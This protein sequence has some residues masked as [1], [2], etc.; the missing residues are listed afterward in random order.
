MYLGCSRGTYKPLGLLLYISKFDSPRKKAAFAG[1]DAT[2]TQSGEFEAAHNVMS[3][4]GLPY[5]RKV[6]F[7][8]LS[9]WQSARL[10]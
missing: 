3:K 9:C 8:R 5:L 1:L 4:R 10:N 6:I 7:S 2:V